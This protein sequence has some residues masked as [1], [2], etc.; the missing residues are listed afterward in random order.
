MPLSP[1]Q[2]AASLAAVLGAAVAC[3][4]WLRGATGARRHATRALVACAL[5]AMAA[6]F[7]FGAL[8][9]IAVDVTPA[10]STARPVKQVRHW[11]L[12]FHELFHYYLGA[13]Y[14][15]E[16]GYGG[17]YDCTA[18]ADREIAR[19]EGV[20]PRISGYVRDLDDVLRDG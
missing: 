16:L 6:W 15:R 7:R 19:E 9:A 11:P 10:T 14:F 13:K 12:Q 20:A 2:I 17:L 8:H 1:A 3:A 5:L 4:L 18:L